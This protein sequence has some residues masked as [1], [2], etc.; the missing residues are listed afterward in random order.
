MGRRPS[1]L[2]YSSGNI[3]LHH[4]SFT[5]ILLSVGSQ[6]VWFPAEPGEISK[7]CDVLQCLHSLWSSEC[8]KWKT[9]HSWWPFQVNLGFISR[10]GLIYSGQE[11]PQEAQ[12]FSLALMFK[13]I[14]FKGTEFGPWC[15]T[16]TD[17]SNM[18]ESTMSR[19]I[20][21][22]DLAVQEQHRNPKAGPVHALLNKT[23]QGLRQPR[24]FFPKLTQ[25]PVQSGFLLPVGCTSCPLPPEA[26]AQNHIQ[27][28]RLSSW[29]WGA[30]GCRGCVDCK[31]VI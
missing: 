7:G 2:I 24:D 17:L 6:G 1:Y 13:Q 21:E 29:G 10:L 12:W 16:C 27:H 3:F 20:P 4:K 23:I 28:S 30:A 15:C 8:I 18:W 26:A 22:G 11:S 19:K 25:P 9:H 5:H 14:K 31:C